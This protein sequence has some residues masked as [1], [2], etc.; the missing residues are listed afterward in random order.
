MSRRT[1]ALSFLLALALMLVATLPLRLVLAAG[2][3]IDPGA[4]GLSADGASGSIWSGRLRSVEWR[5]QALGDATLAL[6]PLSLLRGVQRLEM[7][8]SG[9]SADLLRGRRS[10][11]DHVNGQLQLDIER[12]LPGL[13]ADISF[14]N[15]NLVFSG[16]R[17]QK[18]GGA[19]EA[20]LVVPGL[21]EPIRLQGPVRCDGDAGSI[22]LASIPAPDAPRVEAV[23]DI[24]SDGHYRLQSRVQPAGVLTGLALQAAGFRQT[25]AGLV[26]T[27]SGQWTD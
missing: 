24:E 25:P 27:D 2:P 13:V 20:E 9:L 4:L 12:P 22:A 17:C 11:I 7:A 5:G 19:I 26:R 18:G 16:G 3:G 14:D 15:A 10:G 23:L 6:D 8:T 21:A 1:L